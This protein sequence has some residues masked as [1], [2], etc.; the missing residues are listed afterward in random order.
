VTINAPQFVTPVLA[1]SQLILNWNSGG[2]SGATT[3]L[4]ATNL[5]GPWMMVATNAASPCTIPVDIHRPRMFFIL[6]QQ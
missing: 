4:S 1:N 6:E 2:K 5:A 3:L